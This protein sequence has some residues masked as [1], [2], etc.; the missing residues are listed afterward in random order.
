M[1]QLFIVTLSLNNLAFGDKRRHH[2]IYYRV[3]ATG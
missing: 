2:F 3:F 1:S